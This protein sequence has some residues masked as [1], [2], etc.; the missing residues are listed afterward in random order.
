MS[1]RTTMEVLS[2]AFREMNSLYT[3]CLE[4]EVGSQQE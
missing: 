2:V 1:V 3:D 4:F